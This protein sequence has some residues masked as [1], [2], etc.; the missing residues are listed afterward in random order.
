MPP[1]RPSL[2]EADVL[3]ET[4]FPLAPVALAL[5]DEDMRYIRVNEAHAA[6]VGVPAADHVGRHVSEVVPGAAEQV[7]PVHRRVLGGEPV[8]NVEVRTDTPARPGVERCFL[9]SYYPVEA[10]GRRA[11]GA[12]GI[13]ITKR[14]R[15]EEA[16]RASEE[17]FRSL[18]D[19][20]LVGMDVVDR[21]G[22][23]LRANPALCRVLGRSEDELRGLDLAALVH[24][25]DRERSGVELERLVRGD[26]DSYEL[27]K[28]FVRPDGGVVWARSVAAAVRDEH[29]ELSHVV[30]QL[31]DLTADRLAAERIRS[32]DA[33]LQRAQRLAR[34]GSWEWNAATNEVSWSDEQFRIYGFEPGSVEPSVRLFRE[35]VH[36]D[37]RETVFPAISEAMN[38][39]RGFAF[40][41]R[42]VQPTGAVRALT[43]IGEPVRDERG[44]VECFVGSNVDVT[45]RKRRETERDAV[46][47]LREYA[48]QGWSVTRLADAAAVMCARILGVS[49]GGVLAALPHSQGLRLVAGVGWPAESVGTAVIPAGGAS[50]P[51]YALDARAP[52]VVDDWR[53]EE[54]FPRVLPLPET[55][56]RSAL[57]VPIPAGAEQ[58][59]ILGLQSPE[60]RRF[61]REDVEFVQAVAAALGT[62]IE[63]R[64]SED[65]IAG[66]ADA[67]GRLVAQTLNAEDETRRQI[68]ELLHDHALQEL[69]AAR[70]DLA[71]AEHD[72]TRAAEHAARA[73]ESIERAV[74]QLR[75]AVADLH[76]V[77]LEHGGLVSAL[78]AV[79]EHQARRGGFTPEVI[80][81]PEVAGPHD[82]LLL[83][84]GRELLRNAAKHAAASIV[85]VRARR[86]ADDVVLEVRDDGR[87]FDT[88]RLD[89]AV[90]EGHIGLASHAERVEGVGGRL[91]VSSRPGAG[92]TIRAVLPAAP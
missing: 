55:E 87:G 65:R 18:F 72:E 78:A 67:R 58:F 36:P 40:D 84:L 81:A 42:I 45:E 86:E 52:V 44:Q 43:T 9:V 23:V 62:A 35:L 54:R 32:R 50:H 34:M 80:V 27:E 41:F 4:F 73:R 17:R 85:S 5:V 24:P 31:L 79:A 30:G 38:A 6:I 2:E 83:S 12:V 68:S 3:V 53:T 91:E 7:A 76:P 82:K 14:V 57:A 74:R 10:G 51:G 29:G 15:A 25:D 16:L 11:V 33:Q 49:Y 90:L 13:D 59:G 8:L 92:T 89:G 22:R 28:R 56:L 21:E 47:K 64:R 1:G 69:L 26:A 66:L 75:E 71:E 70:Q 39:G 77:V 19:H 48:L 60:P 63:R 20:A 88:D 37:E 61:G 46:A